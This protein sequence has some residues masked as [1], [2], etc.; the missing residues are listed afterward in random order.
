MPT[1]F[2]ENRNEYKLIEFMFM[3]QSK[4]GKGFCGGMISR[5]LPRVEF[6]KASMTILEIKQFILK[7]VSYIFKKGEQRFQSDDELN[8]L[9]HLHIVNN[10]PIVKAGN[11]KKK[12]NCEF[13]DQ[14]Y[15]HA[16]TCDIVINKLSANSE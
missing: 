11:Y 5:V 3:K 8:E 16:D 7:K 4:S 10:L 6:L 15:S 12:A 9:V 13:C 1:D 14:K 2:E